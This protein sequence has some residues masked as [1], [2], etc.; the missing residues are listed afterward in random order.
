MNIQNMLYGING[1][2][3]EEYQFLLEIIKDM[4]EEKA[5]RF[6]M[7][8]S[9]KRQS[10]DNLL[11]FTLLGFIGL[12]GV[13]RFITRQIGMGILYFFTAG[14]CFIGTIVDLINYKSMANDFNR[15]VAFECA[16]MVNMTYKG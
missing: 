7:F 3:P 8:Y 1:I 5:Q 14:L 10:A 2:T 11:I 15:T 13:Q 6:V 16:Q 9:G 4:D 12:A